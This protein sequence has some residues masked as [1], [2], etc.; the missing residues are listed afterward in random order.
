MRA[1]NPSKYRK[2]IT[3]QGTSTYGR[4]RMTVGEARDEQPR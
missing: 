1:L 2:L 3:D 4:V